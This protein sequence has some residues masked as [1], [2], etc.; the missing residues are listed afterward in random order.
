MPSAA[1]VMNPSDRCRVEPSTS[2]QERQRL[3]IKRQHF[4][5]W[6]QPYF[7][8]MSSTGLV[9]A[10]RRSQPSQL[11]FSTVT[12]SL[13]NSRP[14]PFTATHNSIHE[15]TEVIAQ[16]SSV[17]TTFRMKRTTSTNTKCTH[18]AFRTRH[19]QRMAHTYTRT[20][21]RNNNTTNTQTPTK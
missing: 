21:P 18:V 19:N 16:T 3:A 7:V 20:S 15:I 5:T 14:V 2:E 6:I 10:T 1:K 11:C 9:G 17:R 13:S 8:W 4:L 12:M